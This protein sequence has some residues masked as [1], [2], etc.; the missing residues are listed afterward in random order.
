[1]GILLWVVAGT[2]ALVVARIIPPLRPVQW[3]AEAAGALG[4]AFAAGLTATALDFGGWNEPDPRAACFA[5][6][7]AL[8]LVAA[9]RATR[10]LLQRRRA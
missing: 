7:T 9:L 2:V 8:A 10:Y 4:G 1:M 5:L 3:M 6:F